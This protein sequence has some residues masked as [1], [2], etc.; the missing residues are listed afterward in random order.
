[1]KRSFATLLAIAM[2]GTLW[3]ACSRV[4]ETGQL[5]FGLQLEKEG[6]K[7]ATVTN[8]IAAALVTITGENGETIYDKEYLPVYSFGEGYTTQKLELPLG[9]F[10]LDEFMLVDSSGVVLWA[11]PRE[12]SNLAH[13]VRDP[14]P[15][16]F[17]I[18]PEETTSVD[19]QVVRVGD[20]LPSDF[21][22]VDFNIGFVDRFC[23]KVFYSSRCFEE[24]ND[25]ILGPGS[26]GAPVYQ[27]TL[28][29]W[30]GDRLVLHEPLNPGLNNY[31]LPIANA[32]YTLTATDC[33][34]EVVY[35]NV[36]LLNTLL[37]HRCAEG[38]PPLIIYRD[39]LPGIIITPEGLTAPT[40]EQGV[41]GKLV[42]P[43]SDTL[44][45]TG[46]D[47]IPLVRDIYFYPYS[48]LDSVYTFA[49]MGCYF[50]PDLLWMD[51]VVI[52]RSNSGGIFQAPLREGE[53]L[54]LVKDGDRFY[55]DAFVSSHP[56]GFVKVLPG[57]VTEL[58]ISLI[59]CSLIM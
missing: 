44:S 56:P 9:G 23:L 40:I 13:L 55:M 4:E 42:T 10:L 32:A 26:T 12:G 17:R 45:E 18:S 50:S 39:P 19:V 52:V 25:S 38:Y 1:M 53:Y 51:P 2:A 54:Y 37:Q 28:T 22:Y 43:V 31:P 15:I 11:T 36:F 6:L 34:G 33:H 58:L 14:L 30:I 35:D 57:Q 59:D 24:W 27:P 48:V 49:P 16:Y 21:G 7:T 5:Q 47:M 3:N 20:R 29:I 41:F 8:R 46:S